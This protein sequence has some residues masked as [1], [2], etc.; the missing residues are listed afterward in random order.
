[1]TLHN[2]ILAPL[3]QWYYYFGDYFDQMPTEQSRPRDR[4]LSTPDNAHYHLPAPHQVLW[5][6]AHWLH[7]VLFPGRLIQQ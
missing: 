2:P 4:T 1:M 6:V 5:A 7:R 3:T